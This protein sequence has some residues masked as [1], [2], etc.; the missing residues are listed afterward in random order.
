MQ[1]S[2]IKPIA[3]SHSRI[4]A[5]ENCPL[6][7]KFNYVDGIKRRI[8]TIEAFNGSRCHEVLQKL[9]EDKLRGK[10]N[11]LEDLLAYY[12]EVWQKEWHDDVKIIKTEYTVEHYKNVGR[13]AIED[14][15]NRYK[16]FEAGKTLG[17][18][19]GVR[20]SIKDKQGK[21]YRLLGYI[22]R[23]VEVATGEYE[24]HDYKTANSVPA[25]EEAD[26]DT[27]LALYQIAIDD[28]WPGPKKVYLVWH[29][30]VFDKEIRSYRTAEQIRQ[31]KEALAVS[32]NKIG[33]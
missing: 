24:V 19:K 20:F 21:E 11:S 28:L 22:D 4:N 29:Y 8:D 26:N 15:Y 33:Y 7:Y 31:L 5:F 23:L 27:Q 6:K 3:Y 1:K 30:L 13:K 2:S 25:Q 18:E 10:D 12:K 14:Y 17:L 32:I 9:Y 16:P